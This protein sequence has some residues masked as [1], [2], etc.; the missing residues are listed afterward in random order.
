MTTIQFNTLMKWLT[1]TT[2]L[3]RLNTNK[4]NYISHWLNIMQCLWVCSLTRLITLF[5]ITEIRKLFDLPTRKRRKIVPNRM[6]TITFTFIGVFAALLPHMFNVFWYKLFVLWIN[7]TH[8]VLTV[9]VVIMSTLGDISTS[10]RLLFW[11]CKMIPFF[12]LAY[13]TF[14][15]FGK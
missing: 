7:F 13:P 2:F 6:T 1:D 9:I 11:R 3:D 8:F 15:C 5:T 4:F 14:V 12:H 10:W